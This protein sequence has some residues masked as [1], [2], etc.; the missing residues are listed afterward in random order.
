MY[1]IAKSLAYGYRLKNTPSQI[2]GQRK[3]EKKGEPV[4]AMVKCPYDL[5]VPWLWCTPDSVYRV[6]SS[7]D[8]V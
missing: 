8:I 7:P 4:K 3:Q 2:L 1:K 6:H 5:W